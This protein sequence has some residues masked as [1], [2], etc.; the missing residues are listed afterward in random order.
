M[1]GMLVKFLA[2]AAGRR[3]KSGKLRWVAIFTTDPDFANYT[4]LLP[5]SIQAVRK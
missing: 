5:I 4:K 2:V 3:P 1:K